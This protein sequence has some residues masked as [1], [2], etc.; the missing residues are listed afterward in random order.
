MS[1]LVRFEI[2]KICSR[3]VAQVSFGAILAI[4]C[5]ILCLN[6]VQQR[7]PDPN[8]VDGDLVGTAAIAQMKV[9]ADALAGPVTN[10]RATEALREYKTLLDEYKT[11]LDDEGK[12]K[13]EYR[14]DPGD[15]AISE[16]VATYWRFNAT[17][18]AYLTLLLRPWMVGYQMPK[19]VAAT[20]DTSETVDLYG[21][22]RSNITDQLDATEGTFTYTDAEK[23]FWTSKVDGVSTPVE[24][25][26]AGGWTDFLNLAQY[27]LFAL[28]VIV[29]AC[30]STFNVEYREKTDAVL[31]STKLGKSRL[32]KAKVVAAVIVS[33]GIY[34]LMAFVLLIVPLMFFGADGAGLHLQIM[35]LTY[36]YNLSL[37]AASLVCCFVG[38]LAMLG[39]LGL[40]LALSARMRSSMGI[41]AAGVAIVMVPLYVPNLYNNLANHVMF[42]FPCNALNP[43][44]LFDMVSYSLGPVV[45]EYPVVIA[46][47]YATLFVGSSALAAHSFSKHQVA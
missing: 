43:Y 5:V 16:K 34:W 39:L 18:G 47:L 24:Y 25:G 35:K 9:S 32:G 12:V 7:T 31:L 6:I 45:V 17:H 15:A 14:A 2:K 26:Y 37:L 33:S 46:I 4:L 38:Y 20:I 23:D 44:N 11:L 1:S 19:S 27:L 41:L 22:V 28:L 30:A 10:E 42:L 3:R 36:V 21:Q 13:D 8:Q 40:T 29:I